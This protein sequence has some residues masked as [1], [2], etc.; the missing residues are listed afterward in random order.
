MKNK[1]F[2]LFAAFVF[3][4]FQS[5]AA[6]LPYDDLP[7]NQVNMKASHNTYDRNETV[8]EQISFDRYTPWQGGCSC[9]EFDAMQKEDGWEW[10]VQHNGKYRDAE[11]DQLSYYLKKV[12]E[13]RDDSDNDDDSYKNYDSNRVITIYIDLKNAPMDDYE[14]FYNFNKYIRE[15]FKENREEKKDELFTPVYFK[16]K[17]QEGTTN[18]TEAVNQ[19]KWPKMKDLKNKYII[20]ITGNEERR[21]ADYANRTLTEEGICFVDLQQDKE[22]SEPKLDPNRVFLNFHIYK[23][24]EAQWSKALAT[25]ISAKC[26]VTRGWV[27]NGAEIWNMARAH[28]INILATNKIY[29]S[30]WANVGIA[31]FNILKN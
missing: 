4:A 15:V 17:M 21:K 8:A 6:L 12:K 30:T 28:G 10:S 18:L 26:Y 7:Y 23:D 29:N 25:C 5:F 27:L 14:F 22:S 1:I 9:V 31:P 19:V 3:T 13:W 11:E 24:H 2:F 16:N 20:C